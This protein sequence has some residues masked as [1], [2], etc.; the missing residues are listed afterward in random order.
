MN[1]IY[2]STFSPRN[3]PVFIRKRRSGRRYRSC[4]QGRGLGKMLRGFVQPNLPQAFHGSIPQAFHE[5]FRRPPTEAFRRP[6]TE[7]F[8][9]FTVKK[10]K[11]GFSSVQKFIFY[12]SNSGKCCSE[13]YFLWRN[14]VKRSKS[15][16]L[17]VPDRPK[18]RLQMR[19]S[20]IYPYW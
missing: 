2:F 10:R 7:A 14:T 8:R 3:P 11:N 1:V 13:P 12:G 16:F 6:P 5:A 4:S 17:T 9:P 19:K 20:G 18:I 15:L